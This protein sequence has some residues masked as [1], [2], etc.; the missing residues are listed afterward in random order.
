[1][2]ET[3]EVEELE[4]RIDQ[5]ERDIEKILNNHLDHIENR[6]DQLESSNAEIALGSLVR[7]LAKGLGTVSFVG[8]LISLFK[9]SPLL[10]VP[11]FVTS[12]LC[13]SGFIKSW[14]S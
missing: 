6:L 7:P 9:F 13:L 14:I 4:E 12:L 8:G 2:A 10:S 5:T 3:N 11:L 1:M